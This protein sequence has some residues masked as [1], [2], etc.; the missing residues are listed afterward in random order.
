M[1]IIE[2]MDNTGKTTLAKRLAKDLD[3]LYINNRKKPNGWPDLD[4]DV[5]HFC[6]ISSIFSTVFDRWA[7]IS[8]AIYG[9]VL[10]GKEPNRDEYIQL[11]KFSARENPLVIYCRPKDSTILNFQ[12]DQMDGVKERAKELIIAYDEEMN[13]VRKFL[14]VC[15]YDYENHEYNHLRNIIIEHLK[16]AIH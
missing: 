13:F 11:H 7:A 3:L 16:G 10:R 14:T 8:E 6:W 5:Y 12:E 4:R 1:I 15:E 2:G 9:R